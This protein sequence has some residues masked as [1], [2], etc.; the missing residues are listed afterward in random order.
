M[1]IT[2]KISGIFHKFATKE[3]P[4][5]IQNIINSGYVNILGLNMS[6]FE[7]PSSYKTLNKLFT[8]ELKVAR[9]IDNSIDN[10]IAPADSFVTEANAIE[11]N[12]ALQIKGMK[13]SVNKLLTDEIS[14]KN[15]EKL[16]NGN[17]MNFYLSPKARRSFY[18]KWKSYYRVQNK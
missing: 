14:S 17:F 8:R 7:N 12:T 11:N 9:D 18:W 15:I 10:F 13:Y 2:N 1:H 6:E 16:D 4:S 3:F 5:T